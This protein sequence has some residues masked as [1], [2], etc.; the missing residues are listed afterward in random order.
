MNDRLGH[1]EL[2]CSTRFT[3]AWLLVPCVL[4]SCLQPR[5]GFA[6]TLNLATLSCATYEKEVL[7]STVPG[8]SADPIDTVMWL[9]GFSVAR[10]GERAMYGDSLTAFGFALDAECKNNPDTMLLAAVT[11]VKSK[12]QNP[13]DLTTLPCSLYETRHVALRKSEPEG[14][15]TLT[16]WLYGYA[17]GLTKGHELDAAG[18][19]KFDAQL[20]ERCTRQPEDTLFDAL[21][22]VSKAAPKRAKPKPA[23]TP[24]TAAAGE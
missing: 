15:N 3:G 1:G 16:M 13:M 14:A 4:V 18:L 5:L 10:S 2:P 12:R 8:Y 21:N 7:T 17:V 6:G 20:D 23:P 24:A 9:F 11:S 19:A 22:P